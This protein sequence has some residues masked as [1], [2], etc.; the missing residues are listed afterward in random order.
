MGY[1]VVMLRFVNEAAKTNT[2]KN[3]LREYLF[4]AQ[5]AF[6]GKEI[7]A[8]DLKEIKGS[9]E[10]AHEILFNVAFTEDARANRNTIVKD[11]LKNF[12]YNGRKFTV[13]DN[14]DYIIKSDKPL[15]ITGNDH[16]KVI[17]AKTKELVLIIKYSRA[18]G[19][20]T[21][22]KEGLKVLFTNY[23]INLHF[24][25]SNN[26]VRGQINHYIT[27]ANEM[28][29]FLEWVDKPNNASL[30]RTLIDSEYTKLYNWLE[31]LSYHANPARKPNT[32]DLKYYI[33]KYNLSCKVMFSLAASNKSYLTRNQSSKGELG[34]YYDVA[35]NYATN[36]NGINPSK[37][38]PADVIM[39]GS[40]IDYAP[41][42]IY[43]QDGKMTENKGND[44]VVCAGIS[45]KESEARWGKATDALLN[46][47]GHFISSKNGKSSKKTLRELRNQYLESSFQEEEDNPMVNNYLDVISN[48]C[49]KF[50]FYHLTQ[51]GDSLKEESN[52]SAIDL[53]KI[54][55]IEKLK[56][57]KIE[58]KNGQ[59]QKS[60][61]SLSMK[62]MYNIFF[63]A[64]FASLSEVDIAYLFNESLQLSSKS[65]Y[66]VKDNLDSERV[67]GRFTVTPNMI[68]VRDIEYTGAGEK[69]V[70]RVF[71]PLNIS[72]NDAIR[73]SL[74]PV[75]KG[76][77]EADI[78]QTNTEKEADKG[79]NSSIE[80]KSQ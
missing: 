34:Q 79:L 26:D 67:L 5:E 75:H 69:K 73:N 42:S 40:V 10:R 77:V 57:I 78:R 23:L 48:V 59:N 21:V 50:K 55:N 49:A 37:Q 7:S 24:N 80:F 8:N 3:A 20:D 43:W 63:T 15:Y 17:D 22:Y 6:F 39:I 46:F 19:L 32:N 11:L 14:D 30:K 13:A 62:Q 76:R 66:M 33:D 71:I 45:L 60:L 16:V 65:Y 27:D 31:T 25:E 56:E 35:R 2:L 1:N 58:K 70:T 72:E 44:A 38:H 64:L 52:E 36:K 12:S 9:N 28:A 41:M 29:E 18:K 51:S 74:P 61:K 54:K 47:N 53:S 4:N 68:G